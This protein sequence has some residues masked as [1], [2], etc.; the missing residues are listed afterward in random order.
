ME[1]VE[2]ILHAAPLAVLVKAGLVAVQVAQTALAVGLAVPEISG[3]L[4][5]VRGLQLFRH[6]LEV[7]PLHLL[8]PSWIFLISTLSMNAWNR[9]RSW[10]LAELMYSFSMEQTGNPKSRWSTMVSMTRS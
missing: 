1:V 5:I 3:Q 10:P 8:T 6:A 7:D 4:L 9:V 2:R